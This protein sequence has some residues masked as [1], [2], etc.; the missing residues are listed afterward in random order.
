MARHQPSDPPRKS[1]G[2][3]AQGRRSSRILRDQK[4]RRGP[5]K[6]K[7]PKGTAR[8][9]KAGAKKTTTKNT[10]KKVRKKSS[11]KKPSKGV[12][13]F[14]GFQKKARLVLLFCGVCALGY[15][16]VTGVHQVGQVV[17]DMKIGDMPITMLWAKLKDRVLD[18]DLPTPKKKR[19]P[20]KSIQKAKT[21]ASPSKA[22]AKSPQAIASTGGDV[23][24]PA[25]KRSRSDL[26]APTPEEYVRAASKKPPAKK[27]TGPKDRGRIDAILKK[28]SLK[29]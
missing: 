17:T 9:R 25:S 18:R 20:K 3:I 21:K 23:K 29:K 28:H 4:A 22:Q 12:G 7:A 6:P 24:A 1:A 14:L 11:R 13:A 5:A 19:I 8:K 16:T 2:R 15:F 27:A 10:Q 26:P